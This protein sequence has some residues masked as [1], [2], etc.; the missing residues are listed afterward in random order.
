ML[1]DAILILIFAAAVWRGRKTGIFRMV[2]RL[3][4]FVIAWVLV[5]V[6]REGLMG[7]LTE[8]G[9]Y[10]A[11]YERLLVNVTS[12]S[13]KGEGGMLSAMQMAGTKAAE[14]FATRL[15]EM[16]L[17]AATFFVIVIVVRILIY[18][19]DKTVLHLPL[20]RPLNS[21]L[22]IAASLALTFV[23]VSLIIG[24]F[25][26]T[27][28]CAESEF[29][30]GQMESSFLVRNIFENNTVIEWLTGKG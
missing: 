6:K 25:G 15:T 5:T 3:I 4:S 23:L 24:A 8:K 16:L 27:L 21:V 2:S 10:T 14:G 9:I 13:Q 29:W 28:L 22:G 7:F 12:A 20:V 17:V 26:G 18:I 11:V 30:R 19:L 1:I